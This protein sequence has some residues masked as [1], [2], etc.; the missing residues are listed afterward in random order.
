MTTLFHIYG[1]IAIQTYGL[2]IVFGILTGLFFIKR[3]KPLMKELSFDQVLSLT[4]FVIIAGVVG[5]RLLYLTEHGANSFV[6]A[7]AVWNGG[8]SAFGAVLINLIVLPTYL[9]YKKISVLF[10]LDRISI[11]VPL[12]H[13]IARLGCFFSGCCY[14]KPST[15][16]WAITYTHPENLAPLNQPLIPVQLLTVIGLFCIFLFLYSRRNNTYPR[17]GYLFGSYLYFSGTLR[18]I[19]DFLRSG[20][21]P[22]FLQFS[23]NQVI[24]WCIMFIGLSIKTYS[25]ENKMFKKFNTKDL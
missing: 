10:V 22:W 15:A 19:L 4:S 13:S 5:A 16:W 2:F 25:Q 23:H 6:D 7:I 3:D 11:Y 21:T 24:A 1:P 9:R 8:L 14:G 12:I 20:H 17:P 18:F